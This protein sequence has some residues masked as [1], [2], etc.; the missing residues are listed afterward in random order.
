MRR[1]IFF[2]HMVTLILALLT[3]LTV[4]GGVLTVADIEPISDN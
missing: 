4:S 3:L 2:F 1:Q